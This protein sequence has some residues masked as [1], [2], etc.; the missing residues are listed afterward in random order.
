LSVING[1]AQAALSSATLAAGSHTIQATYKGA[2]TFVASSAIANQTV[3]PAHLTVTANN[4]S[5]VYGSAL[6]AQTYSISGFQNGETQA[7]SG[8]MGTP[9]L[10]TVPAG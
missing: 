3:T 6:P 7:T 8:V 2:G 10:G 5:A 9:V 4:Q 1:V